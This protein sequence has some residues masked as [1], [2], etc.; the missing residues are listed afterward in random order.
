[1]WISAC[2][3]LHSVG[4]PGG[5]CIAIDGRPE[6]TRLTGL[7]RAGRAVAV[8]IIVGAATVERNQAGPGRVE[9]NLG[10][11]REPQL[12][13]DAADMTFHSRLGDPELARDLLV[14]QAACHQ[15]QDLRLALRERL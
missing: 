1:M 7:D 12:G 8:E 5:G 10:P 11:G 13:E 3:L 9:G 2:Y 15:I 6:V 14:R 4:L